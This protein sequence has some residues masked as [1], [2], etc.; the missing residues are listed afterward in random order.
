VVIKKALEFG[1]IVLRQTIPKNKGL[2]MRETRTA[3]TSIFDFYS[4]HE[5]SEFFQN[6]SA[7]LDQYP[8]LLSLIE[9]DLLTQGAKPTGRKGLSV[10]SIF[11]CLLLKQITGVSYEQLSFL[12]T[13]SQSYR[14]FAR[15]DRDCSPG[16][17]ALC[18][19]IRRVRPETLQ[20]VFESLALSAFDEDVMDPQL[21]RLDSTVV[22]SHI[23]SPSDSQLLD[24]GIRVLC[25]LFAQS[26]KRTGVK[27][28]LTD[29]RKQSRKLAGAIFYG[30]K[31][32]KDRLYMKLIPLANQVVRQTHRAIEQVQRKGRAIES[33]PWI[34]NVLHYRHLL[35]RVIDQAERRV[36]NGESVPAPEKI[37]SLFEPHTD[38][39]VKGFRDTDYGH[40]VNLSTDKR[41]F[42]TA[43][44]IEEG[45]PKDSERFIPL[46]AEHERLYGCIPTTT[47]AD[48]C[49]ASANNVDAAKAMGVKRVAFHKKAGITLSQM[50]IKGKTLKKLRDFRAGIE[51]NISTLKRA[52]GGGKAL[53][54]G[55]SGF[56]AY[57]WASVI[58]YNLTRWVRLDSG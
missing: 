42:I 57:V 37:V 26:Q 58:S 25:R 28:R 7:K 35:E 6:L 52:F 27:L 38:I 45:N 18:A 51:A 20:A 2:T 16:K 44:M 12:L 4:K 13:D 10:E 31:V 48:G 21:M 56:M 24:D 50:G 43:V 29:Y 5:R 53:W 11:R 30:E 8:E 32:E 55:E 1:R 47:I 34:D 19:N 33:Q 36:V 9:G 40:K 22:K 39:I 15:L 3:Q 23:A 54:K 49:Y 46:L 41:G 17:S 14:T